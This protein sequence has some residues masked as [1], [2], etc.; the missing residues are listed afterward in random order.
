MEGSNIIMFDGEKKYW[1]IWSLRFKDRATISGY[2]ELLTGTKESPP[3]CNDTNDKEEIRLRK[4]NKI[5]YCELLLDM[6]TEKCIQIV[7]ESRTKELPSG[8]CYK[9]WSNLNSIYKPNDLSSKI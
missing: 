4:M 3:E 6:K 1:N 8:D 2:D 9:A 5:G 7:A